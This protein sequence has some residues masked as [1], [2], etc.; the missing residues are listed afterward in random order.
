MTPDFTWT[1]TDFKA[2]RVALAVLLGLVLLLYFF[3][4][5]KD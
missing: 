4:R 2:L 5:K 1:V 3:F